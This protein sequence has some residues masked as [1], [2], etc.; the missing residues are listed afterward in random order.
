MENMIV[1][2]RYANSDGTVSRRKVR[3]SCGSRN[4]R[5]QGTKARPKV[6]KKRPVRSYTRVALKMQEV[7]TES[8]KAYDAAVAEAEAKALEGIVDENGGLVTS[9]VESTEVTS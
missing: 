6:G 7:I 9:E 1:A 8:R 2:E 5:R 4:A 3:I